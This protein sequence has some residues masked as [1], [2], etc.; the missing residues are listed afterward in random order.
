MLFSWFQR[1]LAQARTLSVWVATLA[2]SVGPVIAG[3]PPESEW[4]RMEWNSH[5]VRRDLSCHGIHLEYYVPPLDPEHP[6]ETP[7]EF[8]FRVVND[9]ATEKWV[10]VRYSLL[11]NDTTDACGGSIVLNSLKPRASSRTPGSTNARPVT[12]TACMASK[13]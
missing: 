5:G 10:I 8:H 6:L 11:L 2:T 9:T 1:G 4:S 12:R 3:Q 7:D 13:S